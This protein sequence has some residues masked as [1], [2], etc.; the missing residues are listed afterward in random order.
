MLLGTHYG[1]PIANW[2]QAKQ[3]VLNLGRKDGTYA[4]VQ[5][6]G[7]LAPLTELVPNLKLPVNCAEV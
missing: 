2:L 3:G 6:D 4:V 7:K 1:L 5:N